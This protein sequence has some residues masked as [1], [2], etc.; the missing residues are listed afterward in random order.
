MAGYRISSTARFSRCISST[1][2]I[3][4][5]LRFVSSAARSPGFSIA[6]PEVMRIFT[7][8]SWAMM[9]ASVVLPSPGGPCSS[10]WSRDSVRRR[11]ASMKIDR[12]C[13]AF[14]C[15]MYSV[16][17]WGR[18]EPSL[19]S[20]LRNVLATIGSSYRSAPKSML[21]CA[22]PLLHHALQRLPDDV[23]QRQRF[24]VDIFQR[25]GDLR[26]ATLMP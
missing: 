12:F 14:S 15:P 6:G 21:M 26:P 3:S 16:S 22:P 24:H 8:I 25:R 1:N 9:P 23:L 5:S 13:L 11:A 20:S 7:P 17:V 4:F 19:A 2:R 18:R 10:T